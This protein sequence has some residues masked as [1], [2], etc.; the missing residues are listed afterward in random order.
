MRFAR[1]YARS[2]PCAV[3]SLALHKHPYLETLLA[4]QI[5]EGGRRERMFTR[6]STGC[7]CKETNKK[8]H[9]DTN[10]EEGRKEAMEERPRSKW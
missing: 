9:F 10:M 7:P 2:D 5:S 3:F 6:I 8:D 1:G 4:R